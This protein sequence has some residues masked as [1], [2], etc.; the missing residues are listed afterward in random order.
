MI[1]EHPNDAQNLLLL[2][3]ELVHAANWIIEYLK[4]EQH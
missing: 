3:P 2:H 4:K 1:C